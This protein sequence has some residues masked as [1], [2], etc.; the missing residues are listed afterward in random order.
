MAEKKIDLFRELMPLLDKAD[1][2]TIAELD[3]DTIKRMSPYIAL[4]VMSAVSNN[5]DSARHAIL[6]INEVVNKEFHNMGKHPK[7]QLMLISQCSVSKVPGFK[8]RVSHYFPGK[9]SGDK[10]FNQIRE[11]YPHWKD[12]EIKMLLKISSKNE[13]IQLALD[14]GFQDG[15][16]KEWT[17]WLKSYGI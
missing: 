1:L 2:Q 10:L 7:L 12:D 4:K 11:W 9:E 13:L 17:K 8:G 3:D 15:A 14:H 5:V 16:V 6:A